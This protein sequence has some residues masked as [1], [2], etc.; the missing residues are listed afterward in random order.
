MTAAAS[1][2]DRAPSRI[3]DQVGFLRDPRRVL[4]IVLISLAGT[5]ITVF[6]VARG[7][8]AG[9][10]ARAYWGG[11][12]VWLDGGDPMLPPQP[13]LPYVYAPWSVPL[14]L[15]WAALPW[16]V[17]WIVWRGVNVLLLIWTAA[18]AY[19]RRPLAT[20]ILLC[21]L[22]A[23]IAATLDT[24]NLTLFCALG[25]WAAQFTG[26]RLGGALWA[27]ATVLKW[28]P[29][30]LWLVLPPRARLWGL[31]WMAIAGILALATWPQTWV[32]IQTAIAFPR[33][34]RL[35]YL[36][37]LWAAVPW[38]WA[39]PR[40]LEPREWRPIAREVLD[41]TATQ[42]RSVRTAPRPRSAAWT[43]VERQ[44]RVLLGLEGTAADAAADPAAE[45]RGVDPIPPAPRG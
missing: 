17:A 13:Y 34:F 19:Q 26:P 20:A 6:L 29:A 7:E 18:W 30:P 41:W 40:L 27:L 31:I 3:P 28:F 15:P 21:I 1:H 38:L 23:P 24:G 14:F 45:P 12:R 2:P 39:R 22:A 37:L 25:V 35:D 42:W 33:P 5:A 8:L 4:A 16:D 11:V 36:L 43:W 10:D 44:V 9:A 32:Q